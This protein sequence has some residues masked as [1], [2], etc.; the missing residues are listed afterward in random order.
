MRMCRI[1]DEAGADDV[2]A[3]VCVHL[4]DRSGSDCDSREVGVEGVSSN[5][6]TTIRTMVISGFAWG[7]GSDR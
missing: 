2:L 1:A 5:L 3:V 7:S 4:S 6:A